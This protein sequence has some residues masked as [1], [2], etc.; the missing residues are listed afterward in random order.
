MTDAKPT[1]PGPQRGWVMVWDPLVRIGHW[2]LLAAV[3]TGLITRGEPH[4]LHE[5][6]GYVVAGYLVFRVV[7]GI[8]GPQRARF[9]DFVRSPIKGLRYLGQ[10]PT[11]R[12]ER[13]LGHS[14]AGGLM[15]VALMGALFG[16]VA[17]GLAIEHRAPVPAWA[18]AVM[19]AEGGEDGEAE[20]GPW[21]EAHE[22][23]ANLVLFLAIAHVA[24]VGLASLAH[25]ENLIRAMIDGRKRAG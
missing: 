25:R 16:T 22:A 15:V 2:V 6:A 20:D 21:G 17:T 4:S 18:T 12:A 13:R 19:P 5:A 23:F 9:E 24:G 7:W 3:A 14:P 1:T 10:L 8:A 11:G